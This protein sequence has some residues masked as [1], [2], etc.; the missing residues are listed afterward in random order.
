MPLKAF[1]DVLANFEAE[2]SGPLLKRL[3]LKRILLDRPVSHL[4]KGLRLKRILLDRPVSHL[5]K[6]VRLKR[7]L[8]DRALRAM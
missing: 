3:R 2:N 8:L 6:G 1:A 7:I 5:L 4:L